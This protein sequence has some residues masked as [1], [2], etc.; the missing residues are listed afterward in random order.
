[1]TE[2]LPVLVGLYGAIPLVIGV[3]AAV[4]QERR[5]AFVALA[6]SLSTAVLGIL[7]TV[8]GLWLAFDAI[9]AVA[10][11]LKTERLSE[12]IAIAMRSTVV[13]LAASVLDLLAAVV[14]LLLSRPRADTT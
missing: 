3:V 12:G 2:L 10:P 13:G 9:D 4:R 7:A 14:A 11:E 1:V 5:L 6:V 8:L